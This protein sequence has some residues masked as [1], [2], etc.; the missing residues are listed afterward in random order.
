MMKL[1]KSVLLNCFI[2]VFLS[3]AIAQQSPNKQSHRCQIQRTSESIKVD[4]V[5]DES[6]WSTSDKISDFNYC[7]PVDDK[8]VED[9]LQ[10]E[11]M[12]R[13]NDKHIYVAAICH[14]S[15]PFLTPTLKRDSRSFWSG[16]LFSV[17]FDPTNDQ[18]NAFGY[19]ANSV[20]VQFDVLVGSNTGTRSSGSSGGFNV[21]WDNTWESESIEYEDKFVVEMAIPFKTLKY[22]NS[23]EWGINFIRSVSKNNSVH[24]WAPVPVQLTAADLGYQGAIEWDAQPP[25]IKSKVTIIPYLLASTFKNIEDG[26][27]AVNRIELGGEAKIALTSN[28]N[29]DLTVNPDFSQVDVD[30]QVTNLTTVNIRFPE[31]RLF[32]VEN[33]D[34]FSNFGIPPMRP[35]FSRKIGLDED[36]AAIPILYGAR[37]SGN[38]TKDLRIGVMNLQTKQSDEFLGQNYTSIAF[39]QRLFGRTL[40]KGY[41]HNRQGYEDGEFTSDNYNRVFGGEFEHR[42]LDGKFRFTS[43]M[44]ISLSNGA[45]EGRGSY[46]WIVAY[47]NRR[48]SLYW[49]IMSIGDNYVSDMGFMSDQFHYN[50]IT[51]ESIAFGYD[52]SFA[53]AAYNM[54]PK[55][56]KINNHSIGILNIAD[57]TVVGKDLFKSV[58]RATHI[59]NFANTAATALT[60]VNHHSDLLFP[61]AFTDEEPLPAQEYNFRYMQFEFI[62]D[63][64][65]AFY[66]SGLLSYGGFYNGNQKGGT[67]QFNYQA[68]PWGVF[69]LNLTQNYLEFP[70]EK[71]ILDH[72]FAIQYPKR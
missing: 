36:G 21:A 28:L 44:G 70:D 63:N 45:I 23:K 48:W 12:I 58:T 53:R 2:S 13:Y 5:L 51:E 46:H 16:D 47:D 38:L 30:E 72:I 54:Y 17:I 55:T 11:V 15:G 39:N 59:I 66:L 49:N 56:D 31:R 8:R 67:L 34:I 9:E 7:F 6:L 33:S 32:F 60:F 1:L 64:R 14:G 20:G 18:N 29:L 10:T 42:S 3:G 24:T 62:T 57:R 25:K 19:S 71:F 68:R 65:K 27:A 26:E 69:A 40:L 37:L 41:L 35:F 22:G 43:G 50:A 4:G 52:H 61:F